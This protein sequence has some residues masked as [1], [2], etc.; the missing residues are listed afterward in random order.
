M[1]FQEREPMAQFSEEEI[2]GDKKEVKGEEEVVEG[3]GKE[4][5][6]EV[7]DKDEGGE[8]GDG[9]EGVE[10]RVGVMISGPSFF[11]RFGQ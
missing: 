2:E 6:E 9:E 1:G 11:A 10:E 3:E 8:E 5:D 7:V 4:V